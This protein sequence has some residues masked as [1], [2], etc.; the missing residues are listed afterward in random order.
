MVG[1]RPAKLSAPP[2]R[3]RFR[4]RIRFRF[5]G[6]L[7]QARDRVREEAAGKARSCSDARQ[8]RRRGAGVRAEPDPGAGGGGRRGGE[9]SSPRPAPRACCPPRAAQ[10]VSALRLPSGWVA[11]PRAPGGRSGVHVACGPTEGAWLAEGVDCSLRLRARSCPGGGRRE[12]PP[13]ARR[14]LLAA[15]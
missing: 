12:C 6:K 8:P 14:G 10:R 1:G 13:R 4:E 5:R 7:P 9:V 15:F 2:L 3:F 11:G